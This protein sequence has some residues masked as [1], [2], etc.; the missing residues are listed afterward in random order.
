MP[1]HR[2]AARSSRHSWRFAA[3]GI[4]IAAI[5]VAGRLAGLASFDPYPTVEIATNPATLA[6]ALA[7]PVLAAAPFIG[8]GSRDG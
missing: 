7:L 4:A 8:L 2:G 5:A 1:G 3:A 6:L